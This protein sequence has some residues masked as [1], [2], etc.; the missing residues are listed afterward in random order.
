MTQEGLENLKKVMRKAIELQAEA[1]V[2]M[3]VLQSIYCDEEYGLDQDAEEHLR[4][5]TS[6][7]RGV[8]DYVMRTTNSVQK[9]Y[10]IERA[11]ARLEDKLDN[12][13]A[14]TE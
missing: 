13:K 11:I 5:T 3:S 1:A 10:G 8:L 12:D 14:R 9:A 6:S 2:V 7:A 4:S